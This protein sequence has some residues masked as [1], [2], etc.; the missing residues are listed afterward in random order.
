MRKS[1][2]VFLK[3]TVLTL[4]IALATLLAIRAWDSQRG[5]PLEPWH[6]HVP[7]ELHADELNHA[8]WAAYIAAENAAFED[9][10]REVTE[11]LPER[12]R[13]PFNRYFADS[14]IYPG[15]FH[16]D[17]NRSYVLEPEHRPAGAVVLL[18][19][20]TDCPYSLRHV[21]RS[22]QA[23]GWVVVAIRLPGHGTVPAGLIEA[24]WEDWVA[25]TRLAVREARRLAGAAVPLHIVGYSNGGALAVKH[26]LDALDDPALARPSRL[27]LIS[28]MIGITRLAR[29]AG[30]V[31]WPAVFPAFAKAAW[32]G[33]VPEVNP[34]SY[35]SFPVHAARQASLLT[36]TLQRQTVQHARTGRIAELPP[37]QTFQSVLDF[38]VSTRAIIDAL[39]QYLPANG[40]ELVL[41]DLNHNAYLGSLLRPGNSVLVNR[42]LPPPPRPFR[43]VVI[44]NS[45]SDSLDVREEVTEAGSTEPRSRALG[46]RYPRNVY[47]LSHV[48]LPFPPNDPLYGTEP[49]ASEDF[50]VRLGA[51]AARGE[52]AA[53]VVSLDLLVRMLSNPFFPYMMGR[54][55]A[56]ILPTKAATSPK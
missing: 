23:R 16:Q 34:F 35:S 17:W 8:D 47:S 51:M 2:L 55:E 54:I 52:R 26:A 53:L 5:E 7:P 4:A 22:Y 41:F 33:I 24:D 29:F 15:H 10:R 46:L 32:L 1:I 3:R 9:V 45:G 50:G 49:D 30:V 14:P 20:L 6:T 43:T 36:Q 38:T 28:P 31:G 48:A 13:V 21:A 44:S 11:K 12:D 42:L 18:H 27:V 19:G 39:Y 40:S 37:I 56:G 25:A